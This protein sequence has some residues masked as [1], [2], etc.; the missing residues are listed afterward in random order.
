[1]TSANP[2]PISAD[3]SLL[4]DQVP[5]E[6][7]RHQRD[8][9][10][11]QS[12]LRFVPV[13]DAGYGCQRQAACQQIKCRARYPQCPLLKFVATLT[14]V[15]FDPAKH[16]PDADRGDDLDERVHT[17]AEQGQRFISRPHPGGNCTF[18]QVVDD[19]E[20]RQIVSTGV[21]ITFRIFVHKLWMIRL[22][23]G[24]L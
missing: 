17:K 24:W 7:D 22:M 21:K 18:Q 16:M 14:A 10:A 11:P 20:Q 23:P 3:D 2:G 12:R 6:S 9:Y 1:M 13:I 15:G 5:H 19:R 4:A 8:G